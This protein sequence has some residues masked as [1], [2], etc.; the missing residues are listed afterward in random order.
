[1]LSGM[2]GDIGPQVFVIGQEKLIF[3]FG[4]AIFGLLIWANKKLGAI[5]SKVNRMDKRLIVIE[6]KLHN[7]TNT[8]GD[9]ET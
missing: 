2:F 8:N 4:G 5:E 9:S 3:T 7:P 6:V 1:M